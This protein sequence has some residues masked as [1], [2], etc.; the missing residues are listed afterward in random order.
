M[1][2]PKLFT[3]AFPVY[4]RTDYFRTALDS[5]VNQTVKCSILV[6]DNNSPHDDFKEIVD[7]YNNPLIKYIKT[8]ETVHQDENFNNCIR[9]CE[10]PWLTILH[11]DDTLHCQYVELAMKLISENEDLGGFAVDCNVGAEEWQGIHEK[12][13]FTDD[14]KQVAEPYFYFTNLSAFPGVSFR[15]D[16]ALKLGGF[17]V[18]LHP[19][20]DNDFWYRISM[21]SRVLLVNQQFA[22]YRISPTQSTNR[23]MEAMI[24]D[25]YMYRLN[26]MKNGRYNNILTRLALEEARLNNI[27]YFFKMYNEVQLPPKLY[28][29]GW[30]NFTKLFL[31]IPGT[32]ALI[33]RYK[34]KISFVRQRI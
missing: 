9:Y 32:L 30:M 21:E 22:Y 34:G 4:N 17:N 33:Y 2:V 20:G 23:L 13:E 3:I 16:I 31:L 26:L 6:I 24:N 14:I 8:D 12:V 18:D 15:K 28:N 19:I 7:S 29:K 25:V 10:T 1:D 11:D 27:K 5:A